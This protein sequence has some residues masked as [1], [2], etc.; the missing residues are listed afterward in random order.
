MRDIPPAL[1]ASLGDEVT[2]LAFCWRVQRADGIV[3]GFTSHDRPIILDG[4][5]YEPAPGMTPSAVS[6]SD[7]LEGG[8]ME[9][10][11]ALSSSAIR[12][13][14]IASGRYDAARVSLLIADWRRPV[15]GSAVLARGVLGD[16]AQRDGT[17][18]ATLQTVQSQLSAIPVELCSPEC[19]A[20]FGD[21][22]CRVNLALH[23]RIA[24]VVAVTGD[25]E[26]DVDASSAIDV[27]AYGR[28]RP[29]EGSLAGM[30]FEIV[31]SDGAH[32]ALRDAIAGK[33]SPGTRVELREGCDRRYS[34]CRDRFSNQLNF[35]GEP[36]VPGTDSVI[37][38][39]SL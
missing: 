15:D 23:T 18:E 12:A 17:F 13:D 3:I 31:A 26:I 29:I 19:R 34:T 5:G 14:D 39:P 22:R 21:A 36:H 4:L 8:G 37:R 10:T 33:L 20:R 35:R 7:D 6:A 1:K 2:S 9:V 38:Y 30:D 16:I 32:V 28:L 25:S 27:L 24:T 11:G